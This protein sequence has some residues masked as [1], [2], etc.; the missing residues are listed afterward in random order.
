MNSLKK[1]KKW[2]ALFFTCI[3]LQQVHVLSYNQGYDARHL[4]QSI[5]DQNKTKDDWTKLISC[6]YEDIIIDY[7]KLS[8]LSMHVLQMTKIDSILKEIKELKNVK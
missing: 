8:P 6:N 7:S 5:F 1:Y 3:I 2:I 4:E